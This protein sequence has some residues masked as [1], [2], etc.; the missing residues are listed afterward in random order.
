M[1]PA[2]H[3]LDS[4]A[5]LIEAASGLRYAAAL[6]CATR[7]S[8]RVPLDQHALPGGGKIVLA[9]RSVRR[10][11]RRPEFRP[12][13]LPE[14][15]DAGAGLERPR[16]GHGLQRVPALPGSD[17]GPVSERGRTGQRHPPALSTHQAPAHLFIGR[18][19]ADS[20]PGRVLRHGGD[21]RGLDRQ[22]P[23]QQRGRTRG[24]GRAVAQA[25]EH[26][27]RD[28]RQRDDPARRRQRRPVDRLHRPCPRPA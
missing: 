27:P 10:D 5:G 16:R 11:D 22:A 1:N 6:L 15:A 12:V 17:Q 18:E 21:G 25:R 28:G 3:A 20:A 4:M 24:P 7:R 13:G 26:H 2:K 9:R 14:P 19:P 8:P 23:A